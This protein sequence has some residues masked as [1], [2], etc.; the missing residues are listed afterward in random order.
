MAVRAAGLMAVVLVLLLV[1]VCG[2]GSFWLQAQ[3]LLFIWQL[4]ERTEEYLRGVR[5]DMGLRDPRFH[6]PFREV[7]STRVC[8]LPVAPRP[9]PCLDAT[10][11]CCGAAWVCAPLVARLGCSAPR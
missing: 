2:A 9:P 10:L 7:P 3:C 5:T 1:V 6:F 8:C 4:N 11:A